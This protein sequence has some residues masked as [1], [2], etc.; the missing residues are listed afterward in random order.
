[1]KTVYF[2]NTMLPLAL[3]SEEGAMSQ[4]KQEVQL[5]RLEIGKKMDCLLESPKEAW[6]WDTLVLIR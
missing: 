3:K 1:M 4:G 5:W 2:E 6:Y